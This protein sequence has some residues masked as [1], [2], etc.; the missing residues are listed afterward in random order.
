[1]FR[2]PHYLEKE[3]MQRFF[4]DA[5]LTLLGNG[6]HQTKTGYRFVVHNRSTFNFHY[7]E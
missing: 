7:S 4:L 6:Q 2:S 5:P 1:M 3:G